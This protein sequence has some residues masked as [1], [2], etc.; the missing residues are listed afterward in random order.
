MSERYPYQVAPDLVKRFQNDGFVVTPDVL[1]A[2]EL[3]TYGAAVDAEVAERT[4]A[5]TRAVAEKTRYEQS[6][7]QCMRL[8]ETSPEVRP[9]TCHAALAGIATQL[10][11]E[12][13]VRLWQDQALYK[14]AGGAETTAHQDQTFW[15]LGEEPLVSA[16]I[17]FEDV[18]VAGGAMAYVPGSHKVGR[19]KIVDITHNSEPY[20]IL[21]D[22]ELDGRTPQFVEVKAGSVIWHHGFTVHMAAANT[23]ATTRRVFTVVYL[24]DQARRAR[25]W[26][27]F[28]LDRDGVGVGELIEGPGM[29]RLWPPAA[30]L[31]VPPNMVGEQTGP[32]YRAPRERN[33]RNS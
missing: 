4:A 28:P 22:P 10:L 18:T 25:D 5:D 29:P 15:P 3:E 8:W 31:P 24:G 23:L 20:D 16:W 11:G 30:E 13:G 17:P 19:L 6:F 26:P 21:N 14:E 9:L 2:T 33:R 1:S 12:A 7:V 27:V 32:Q